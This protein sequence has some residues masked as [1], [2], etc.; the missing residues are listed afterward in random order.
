MADKV[1]KVAVQE[2]IDKMKENPSSRFSKSDYQMLVY[3]V[4]ADKD[5]KAKRYLD[6][7]NEEEMDIQGGMFKFLDKLLKHAG[8]TDAGERQKVLDTFEFGVRDVEWV[9]DAV[10]EAMSIYIECGKSYRMFREK[11]ISLAVKK[12][13]RSGKYE[14]K[15]GFKKSIMDKSL[16]AAKA[17]NKK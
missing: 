5:F 10:D 7:E 9:S 15:V 12:I 11:M 4:L 8:M 1:V 2:M 3:G 16:K 17:A 6:P 14:G 13:K